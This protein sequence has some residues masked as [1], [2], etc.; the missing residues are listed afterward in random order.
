MSAYG[1]AVLII[2]GREFDIEKRLDAIDAADERTTAL[3]AKLDRK[4]V[5]IMASLKDILT[6]IGNWGTS[7]RDKAIAA[8]TARAAEQ[9]AR[10]AAEAHAQS[11]I[12]NDAAED[13]AQLEQAKADAVAEA[14]STR[15][16][17]F[18]LDTPPV[19]PPTTDPTDDGGDDGE[20]SE[21]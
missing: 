2:F 19:D 5:R 8:E 10:E 16:A 6:E 3:L 14:T 1:R 12:D 11:V 9:T 15:D 7:W 18:A 17:L 13:Q 4:L 20:P 21:N